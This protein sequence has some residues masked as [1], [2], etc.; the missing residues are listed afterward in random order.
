[1]NTLRI[2]VTFDLQDTSSLART[3]V[4]TYAT[5]FHRHLVG[6]FKDVLYEWG[7]RII[8]EQRDIFSHQIAEG[9]GQTNKVEST[10]AK[11][12]QIYKDLWR[13]R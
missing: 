11:S 7:T 10:E 6:I 12:L 2:H 4:S 3:F 13:D 9:T 5:T 1:M 8:G